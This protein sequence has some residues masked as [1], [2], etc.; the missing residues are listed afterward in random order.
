MLQKLANS[1]CKTIIHS[2]ID[3]FNENEKKIKEK[4]S[5]FNTILNIRDGDKDSNNSLR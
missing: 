5:L 1:I 3:K 2:T 4:N